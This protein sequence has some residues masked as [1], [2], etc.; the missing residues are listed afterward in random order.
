MQVI[1]QFK[2]LLYSV[3]DYVKLLLYLDTDNITFRLLLS[4]DGDYLFTRCRLCKSIDYWCT[5]ISKTTFYKNLL[6]KNS[7][8]LKA[9]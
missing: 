7:H 1:E 9:P 4:L 2:L 8:F 6:I 3:T 5:Q